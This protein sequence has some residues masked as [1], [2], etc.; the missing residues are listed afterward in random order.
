MNLE[1]FH[2]QGP[3]LITPTVH[4]DERG[5]FMESFNAERFST[6]T[7]VTLAFVQDNHCLS[8]KTGTVRGLH[9]QAPPYDQGKLV[10]CIRGSVRDVIVDIRRNSPSYGDKISVDLTETNRNIFWVPPGFLHGYATLEPNTEFLYKVTAGY[11]KASEGAVLWNDP[12]LAI[13]WGLGDNAPA[14]SDK[15]AL[16]PLFADFTS[17]F[18]TAP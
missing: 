5:F 1:T 14:I 13:E 7:G 9:Y 11:N 17:P 15:D 18:E 2:I 10:R 12:D 4:K 6:L 16:A 8:H 3:V